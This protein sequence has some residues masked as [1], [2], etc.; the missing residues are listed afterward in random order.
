[1][2]PKKCRWIVNRPKVCF[3]KPQG[4]RMHQ[5]PVQTLSEEGLEAI[6]LADMEQLDQE[7]AA[8][9]MGISRSTFSR[10]VNDSR[11]VIATALVTGCALKIEGGHFTVLD[12]EN[13]SLY[14]DETKKGGLKDTQ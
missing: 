2:R 10:L 7:V 3:F 4:V 11:K 5:L 1:M 8:S 14:E 9:N 12:S 13:E 6:R